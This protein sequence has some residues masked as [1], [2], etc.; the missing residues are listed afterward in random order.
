MEASERRQKILD[1]LDDLFHEVGLAGMTMS[2]VARRAGMSKQTLYGL[3]QDRD[4]LF[5]AYLE[6]RFCHGD[7]E[8]CCLDDDRDL[9]AR[10]R[11][12]FRFD[13]PCDAWELPIALF[14]LA[15]AEAQN[16]PRLARRCLEE[17]PRY[18]QQRLKYELE[19]A[20]ARGEL[21]VRDTD[22]ASALLLD[23]L[24]LSVLETLIDTHH[25]PSPA[26][27]EARFNLG[28]SVFLKGIS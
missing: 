14:R 16:H 19:R 20:C 10:L 25:R 8:A 27:W 18:K 23:M 9:S 24:H 3:F 28:L 7:P 26:A 12:M 1:A 22:A 13:Q 15:V 21:S 2:A 4:S 11:D 6:Q 5:E 17:G